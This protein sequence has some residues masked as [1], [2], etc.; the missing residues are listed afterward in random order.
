MLQLEL[1]AQ[2]SRFWTLASPLLALVLTVL[3]GA[4]L[5]VALGKDPLRGL[6]MFFWLPI[7]S[8]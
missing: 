4:A 2:S 5:F 8:A 1:R 3:V 6:S 7:S